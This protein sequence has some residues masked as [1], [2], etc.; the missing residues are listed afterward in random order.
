M[1]YILNLLSF[2][3][4][5]NL[6]SCQDVSLT[7]IFPPTT[8]T[9]EGELIYQLAGV[10]TKLTTD[11]TYGQG[12]FGYLNAGADECFRNGTNAS[13]VFPELYNIDSS[14]KNITALW[15]SLYQGIERANIILD[16]IDQPAMDSVKRNDYKGQAIF[17]RA[18]YHYL[19]VT[20][21]GDVPI[22]TT[23]SSDMG[24]SFNLARIPSKD[25]YAL[26]ISEMV[27]AE[28]L[29]RPMS[30]VNS[31]TYVTKSAVQAILAR[32]CLSMA[33]NPIN[34]IS[35]YNDALY[36]STKVISSSY[37]SLNSTPV[38]MTNFAATP[39]YSQL[40]INNMQN[41]VNG[42]QTKE[43]IWD[44]AFLSKSNTSGNYV[45]TGF[46]AQTLGS[47]MGVYCLN[48][49]A[50]G[51]V[52]Y[53][54]GIYRVFPKLYN[55]YGPGDLRRDWAIAPYLYKDA[56][57]TKYYSLKVNITGGGG[58][59]AAAT[60]Y[61]NSAGAITSIVVDAPGTGYT[62][63]PSITFEA[64]KTSNDTV[65][66][67][68]T[69]SKPATATAVVA[70]G[71]LTAINVVKGST[72]YP[73][74]YDRCV[75]K[76]RREYEINLP[77]VRSQN[78]TSCNFPIVRY[79]D[80][81]LMIAEADLMVNNGTPSPAAVEYYNQVRRRAYGYNVVTPATGFDVSTFTLKDIMDERARELCFEGLRRNDLMRWGVMKDVMQNLLD[82][83]SVNAPASYSLTSTAAA[84]K[85]LVNPT[86]YNLFPIPATEIVVESALTQNPGW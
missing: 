76:W 68:N 80:V 79:A 6:T 69:G 27:K 41:V 54:G 2:I 71:K 22:K 18:Y 43:D 60:A 46:V 84:K 14:D 26:V 30:V 17:L 21:F 48:A 16:V 31:T 29:V 33:G 35:K 10:Y 47:I 50:N 57:A 51:I 66:L 72:A 65:R 59:G 81:L 1:K 7:P 58:T 78:Y 23:L 36:W 42:N 25:V 61:T 20:M 83:N 86:K 56:T 13:S 5:I 19:L 77:P 11:Q 45:G 49:S 73:T 8:V 38:V 24:T 37:H 4:I 75:G 52:G 55:L 40:F 9:T 12:I 64:Y 67:N 53:S 28:K 62:S 74:V 15:R 32:V 70:G 82:F 39:A 3:V 34:D 44:A 85:Y 63:V